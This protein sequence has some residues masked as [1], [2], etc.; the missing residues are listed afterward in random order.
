MP[1]PIVNYRLAKYSIQV[2]GPDSLVA[3][4]TPRVGGERIYATS[5][6]VISDLTLRAQRQQKGR[7]IPEISKLR[8]YYKRS[9]LL[10]Y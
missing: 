1:Q 7:G 9:V 6:S 5:Y 3:S 8:R 10:L 2:Q 4:R